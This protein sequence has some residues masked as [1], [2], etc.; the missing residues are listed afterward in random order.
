MILYYA[1]TT[2]HILCCMLHRMTQ[3]KD[4][5]AT[6]LLSN[7]HFNSVAGLKKYESSDIFNEIKII[8]ELECL[9]QTRRKEKRGEHVQKI[10]RKEAKTFYKKLPV[11]LPDYD[12]VILCSDHFPMGWAMLTKRI[13]YDYIEEACGS[14]SQQE[15]I[16]SNMKRNK[17]QYESLAFMQYFGQS[18]LVK[19][20]YAD[21]ERQEPN[22]KNKKMKDFSV[23]KILKNMS[24]EE[25]TKILHFFG[26]Q[27]YQWT[28]RKVALILTQN[29]ENLGLRS[30]QEQHLLY[31]LLADYFCQGM[32]LVVKPHPDDIAGMYQECFRGE[33]TVLP[34]NAPSELLPY[35]WPGTFDLGITVSSTAILGL[36]D[37]LQRQVSFDIRIHTDFKQIHRY[38]A[39]MVLIQAWGLPAWDYGLNDRLW[40]ELG[41]VML[42]PGLVKGRAENL[43]DV[44]GVLV[45]DQVEDSMVD[46]LQSRDEGEPVIFL[47][48]QEDY[49]Y[50]DGKN[51]KVFENI[52]PLVLQKMQDGVSKEKEE[53]IWIYAKGGNKKV[54]ENISWERHLKYTGLTLY[55]E[56]IGCKEEW[57]IKV[58]EGVLKATEA[59]L[60]EY[61]KENAILREKL[62]ARQVE[63]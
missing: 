2:Y 55:I 5:S 16:R 14:L 36:A 10:I 45:V 37:R 34:F 27:V 13:S 19:T 20:I 1:L 59:R 52:R 28:D 43:R 17:T 56:G 33:A 6:L 62:K 31:Q 42:Q 25:Q 15:L 54:A 4:E 23:K 49:R 51:Y 24:P 21:I 29:M 26:M 9:V 50:F 35:C 12:E 32:Q 40:D 8:D 61:E 60:L 63:K 47:N 57:K 22:Y 38:A 3:R 7:I 53:Y 30:L 58:L 41:M 46:F 48:T 18:P 39:A 44:P 11:H